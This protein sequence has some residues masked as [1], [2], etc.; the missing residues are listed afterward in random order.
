MS[1]RL[2]DAVRDHRVAIEFVVLW[3][4]SY[5]GVAESEVGFFVLL[6]D[7]GGDHGGQGGFALSVPN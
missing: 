4:A 1:G 5:A 6:E 2:C 3:S 7:V